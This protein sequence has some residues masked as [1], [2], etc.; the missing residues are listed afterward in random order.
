M[1]AL[2]QS[3]VRVSL[4]KSGF[5]VIFQFAD[6]VASFRFATL[7][8]LLCWIPLPPE[9]QHDDFPRY[10]TNSLYSVRR[11]G[12]RPPQ[13]TGRPNPVGRRKVT[14]HTVT[15]GVFLLPMLAM[16]I[17]ALHLQPS[18]AAAAISSDERVDLLLHH[19]SIFLHDSIPGNETATAT[20]DDNTLVDYPCTID[21]LSAT[22]FWNKFPH[23]LP[24]LY[25]RPII[26]VSTKDDNDHHDDDDNRRCHDNQAFR[27]M[28][29]PG[30]LVDFFGNDF[31]VT[32]TS[33][34]ALSEHSR[35]VP[36][37][38]YLREI[39][40]ESQVPVDRPSNETWYLFGNTHSD[41]WKALLRHYH[42]PPYCAVCRQDNGDNNN[43]DDAGDDEHRPMCSSSSSQSSSSSLLAHSFGVG[44]RG[45]GV[46][47]HVH[48]PGVAET[49]HGR[50]HW[51]LYPYVL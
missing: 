36:L 24:P 39:W 6:S 15:A 34:N 43:D 41:R 4:V 26:I 47:W 21:R 8:L 48:G 2:H 51:L 45:S 22:E 20:S 18:A 44:H 25:P 30:G 37:V 9:T 50:K 10:Q 5:T 32:L 23:G 38:Q 29:T 17:I 13:Q 11:H 1:T 42:T 3:W 27:H 49:L 46:Q 35:V 12:R 14:F 16:T 7:M 33:S 31:N 40:R 19:N 28:T